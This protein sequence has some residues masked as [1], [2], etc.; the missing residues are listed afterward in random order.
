MV[1][2]PHTSLLYIHGLGCSCP[3]AIT[4][5]FEV[6][7][8]RESARHFHRFLTCRKINFQKLKGCIEDPFILNRDPHDFKYNK[9]RDLFKVKLYTIRSETK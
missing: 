2:H 8:S 1:L 4:Y 5:G 9:I 7:C 6:M 3:A